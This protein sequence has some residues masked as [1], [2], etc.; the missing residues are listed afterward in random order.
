VAAALDAIA[1]LKVRHGRKRNFMKQPVS[2]PPS[3]SC[4]RDRMGAGA[5]D[6][7]ALSIQRDRPV[8][9]RW[10]AATE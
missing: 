7:P 5:F 9:S 1:D 10:I 3:R 6:S 4:R 2:T 8:L